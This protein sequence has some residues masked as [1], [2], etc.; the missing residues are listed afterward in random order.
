MSRS[1]A[2]V[3]F[4]IDGTLMRGA[5]QHHKQALIEG[6]RIV[7]GVT[8]HLEGVPTSGMLDRDLIVNML[9]AGGYNKRPTRMVLR[10]VMAEC[11]DAYIAN[12]AT[13][14]SPLLCA[15]VRDFVLEVK[16]RGGALGLVTGNLSR[17]GWKKLELAGL[18]NFFSVGAFAEDGTT[19][20]RLARV[21]VQ[22]ARKE[23]LVTRDCRITLIGDHMNDVQAARANGYVSVA[24]ATGLTS[25]DDL[26]QARPDYVVRDL[27]DLAVDSLM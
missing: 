17:I 25:I 26:R 16:R 8:T 3:L 22:R 4:D 2:L 15:G 13:D 5:G 19:R 12:C 27:R 7:A 21:A 20:A 6:I 14:L 11:Q 24:V 1:K 10:K 18:R 9:R 23:G